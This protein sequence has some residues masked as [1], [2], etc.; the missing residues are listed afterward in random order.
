MDEDL[1]YQAIFKRKSVREIDPTPLDKVTLDRIISQSPSIKRI[2]PSIRTELRIM[3]GKD[4]KGMFK[5]NA[6]HFLAIFSERKEGYLVNAG[7]MLQQMDLY[8]SA[9]GLG[10]CWQG[11]PKPTKDAEL[12]EGL[13]F[14]IMLAF[15]KPQERLHRESVSEFKRVP[16]SKITD[17]SGR[18][19]LIE[20]ARLAPSGMNN[21]PWY[22]SDGN[23]A[24]DAFYH[25]SLVADHMNQ[26]SVGIA[27]NHVWLTARHLGK[28]A[29]LTIDQRPSREGPRRY[30]YAASIRL[31]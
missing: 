3:T 15:G 23:G 11:G 1:L 6:P 29:D 22:F 2:L 30:A 5:V 27:L 10:S 25:K 14:V 20:P 21:Q 4:V 16:L 13:E 12:V 24:I 18:D 26:I 9:N 31:S 19:E 28:N 8:L 7:F 17:I